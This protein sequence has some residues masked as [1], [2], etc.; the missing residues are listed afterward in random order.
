MAKTITIKY[1]AVTAP[2]ANPVAE[3][4]A[5]FY[6]N[7]AAADLAV[8][9]GT[10][11]DTNVAGIGEGLS[12]EAFMAKQVAFPGL[13]AALRKAVKDGEYTFTTEDEKLVLYLGEVA[14]A[15]ADQGFE[16]TLGE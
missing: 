1:T 12:L 3:I 4:P 10:Y 6:P 5:V 7:N 8:F 13:V 2:V 16:I 9:E 14:P 15:I 11:Y